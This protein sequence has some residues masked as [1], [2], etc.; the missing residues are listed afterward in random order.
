[1]AVIAGKFGYDLEDPDGQ[2]LEAEYLARDA[3]EANFLGV[4]TQELRRRTIERIE[5]PIA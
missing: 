1:V 5:C 2:L 3:V 4:L